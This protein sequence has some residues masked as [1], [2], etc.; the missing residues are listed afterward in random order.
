M[1][2]MIM[3]FDL[4]AGDSKTVMSIIEQGGRMVWAGTIEDNHWMSQ[5]VWYKPWTWFKKPI[6]V[7]DKMI[8]DHVSIGPAPFR[9]HRDDQQS[10]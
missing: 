2:D 8:M 10:T 7:I 4:S 9:V 5:R 3:G 6:R 1:D